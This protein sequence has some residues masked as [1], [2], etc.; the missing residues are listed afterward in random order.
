MVTDL[1]VI[2]WCLL[3]TNNEARSAG[4]MFVRVVQ[5]LSVDILILLCKI[6]RNKNRIINK[7][8]SF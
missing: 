1:V 4:L 6:L 5:L 8:L 2:Y 7:C 3:S